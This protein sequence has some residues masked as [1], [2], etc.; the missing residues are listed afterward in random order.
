VDTDGAHHERQKRKDEGGAG[1]GAV[2]R[3][4]QD[5]E[6]G[7]PRG[8]CGEP[9]SAQTSLRHAATPGNI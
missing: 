4:P 5:A 9:A 2:L 1:E 3:E 8:A 7:P 6:L